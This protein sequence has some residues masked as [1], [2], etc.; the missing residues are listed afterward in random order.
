MLS[1]YIRLRDDCVLCQK[2][3]KAKNENDFLFDGG[4]H[5]L[6]YKSPFAQ[7]WP[8]ALMA[9]YKR[10][11]YEH[12]QIRGNELLDT[13][14][15][16]VCLEKAIIKV[17]KCKRI[18]FVKF[19]NVANHLHWHIIPR[20]YKEI[21]LEKCSWELSDIS[22]EDLYKNIEPNFFVKNQNLYANLKKEYTFEIHH[23]ESS[24]FG[25]ALFLRA[26]DKNIRNN[27]WKLSLDEIIKSAR[28][29]P[30]EWECLL[31]KRN[32]FD[33][34]W[35]FIGGNSDINEFP[36]YTMIREVKEEVGWKI[37]HYK[38]ICRQW[39]QGTIKGFVY[40]AIPEEKQYMDDDP[41][42]TPC[43][44]VQTVKYF[45][46]CEIINSNHFSDSVKGRIKAFIDKRS[47][48]L[49]IDP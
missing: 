10:H 36:E 29:K 31:M 4:N 37:L 21:Y 2:L 41:P 16:L 19:A 35:D 49:S 46:L 14:Q 38:E 26:S 45:N 32:Y 28:E 12:S 1:P 39:K 6:V 20:Y 7:K 47:D 18:N 25:C 33:F 23:R 9:V 5:F 24:Y 43:D 17:T 42:R 22:K 40:L 15:S 30:S 3:M 8:G 34:A 27:I 13:L 11:I 48:F 44:E